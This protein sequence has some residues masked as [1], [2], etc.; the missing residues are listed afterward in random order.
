[1]ICMDPPVEEK[2]PRNS[3]LCSNWTFSVPVFRGW[4]KGNN[5]A[6]AVQFSSTLLHP[7][8]LFFLCLSQ[9]ANGQRNLLRGLHWIIERNVLCRRREKKKNGSIEILLWRKD[10]EGFEPVTCQSFSFFTVWERRASSML[11]F[12]HRSLGKL[13]CVSWLWKE[14]ASCATAPW[15]FHRDFQSLNR[16]TNAPK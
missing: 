4:N 3:H 9:F 10:V 1:M 2:N 11:P 8:F 13:G 6:V 16:D 12:P 5:L 15:K 7:C 14:I